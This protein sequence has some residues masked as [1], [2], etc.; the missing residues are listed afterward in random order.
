MSYAV[1]IARKCQESTVYG[2]RFYSEIS[3]IMS[4]STKKEKKANKVLSYVFKTT[5]VKGELKFTRGQVVNMS[6]CEAKEFA[7]WIYP[8]N[9]IDAK[10][11]CGC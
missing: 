4:E 11:D 8:L 7:R 3:G 2:Q 6:P 1:L 9:P 5:Y 10:T